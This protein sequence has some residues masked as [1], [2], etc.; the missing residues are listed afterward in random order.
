MDWLSSSKGL[1]WIYG[2]PG[3]GKSTLMN[4]LAHNNRIKSDLERYCPIEWI[5]LRFFFDFRTGKG[6]T[7][8]FEGLLRSLLHQLINEIPQIDVRG[9]DD[10]EKD[11]ISGWPEHRLRDALRR[12]L[13][14]AKNGVCILVDG[15]DEYEG[16]FLTL[17][18]FLQ[19]LAT[20][21]DSEKFPIKICVSSRP[22]PVLSQYLQHLPQLSM[23]DHNASGIQS[24]CSLTIEEMKLVV[25][26]GMNISRLSQL[27]SERAEG[28]FLWARFALEELVQGH[29][30]GETFEEI[31]RRLRSIPDSLEEIYDR[32]LCRIP[33]LAKKECMVML[34]LVCFAI[35]PLSLQEHH[36]ATEIAMGR[37]V[38]IIEPSDGDKVSGSVLEMYNTYAKR[39]RAKAVGLLELVKHDRSRRLTVKLIHRS[40]STFL[41]QKGWQILGESGSYDSAKHHSW[42]VGICTRYL[43]RL[44]R[45][46]CPED[47]TS[48]GTGQDWFGANG[49][50]YGR[51]GVEEDQVKSSYPF[52]TYS[53]GYIFAHARSV[54]RQGVSSYPL[55][56][57]S[58]TEQLVGLHTFCVTQQ[59][60]RSAC[61]PCYFSSLKNLVFKDFDP[62]FVAFLH[63]LV[64]YCKSDLATRVPAPGQKFWDRAL[65]CTIYSTPALN[66]D[67]AQETSSLALQ[68]I[69]S[70]QQ[71]HIEDSLKFADSLNPDSRKVLKLVLGHES[72]KDL[73]LTD[74]EGQEVKFL[75]LYAQYDRLLH[76]EVLELLVDAAKRRGED[77]RQSCGPEGNL[78]ETLLKQPPSYVRKEKLKFLRDYYQSMSWPF[79]YDSD[80]IE[81][82]S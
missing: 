67:I 47:N 54:E 26:E 1:F 59:L 33:P 43:H 62:I 52:F 14:G 63:G 57:D 41:D 50:L 40:V 65:T 44:L 39:L 4:H 53:S 80:E 78:A 11:S 48:Q 5:V 24:Y 8:S 60:G 79:E 6:V 29:S 35:K 72:V 81:R 66:D 13:E 34:Q 9:L 38:V 20:S 32:M 76:Y 58:L 68:N 10:G 7:N 25:L 70:V 21:N 30:S 46:L 23:S 16:S 73:R 71:H 17:I 45:H 75:S 51:L 19:S 12:S 3:S 64:A 27:I 28:V 77:V 74:G 56:H 15:L 55:L 37:D 49:K 61:R 31:L 18:P 2:K 69:T 42:Y 82:K 36:A 22:E